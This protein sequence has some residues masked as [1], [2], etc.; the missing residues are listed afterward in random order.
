MASNTPESFRGAK[1]DGSSIHVTVEDLVLPGDALVPFRVSDVVRTAMWHLLMHLCC[2]F[3]IR[4]T[5][6]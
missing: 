3:H 2:A 6:Q 1:S 4:T 5:V